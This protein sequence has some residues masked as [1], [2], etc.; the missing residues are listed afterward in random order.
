M[1]Q[2]TPQMRIFVAVNPVDFRSGIDCL[3]RICRQ[4]LKADPFL[5]GELQYVA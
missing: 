2:I 5:C 3:C 1:I 4:I